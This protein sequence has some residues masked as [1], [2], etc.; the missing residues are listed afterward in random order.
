MR[1]KWLVKKTIHALNN[2]NK[3]TVHPIGQTGYYLFYNVPD[4]KKKL[5]YLL[6]HSLTVK[7]I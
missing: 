1:F 5:S 4:I 3:I 7:N 2:T 6:T